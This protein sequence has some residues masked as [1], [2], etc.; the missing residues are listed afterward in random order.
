MEHL[1]S[2]SP[3]IKV[4][5]KWLSQEWGREQGYTLGDTEA[6]CREVGVSLLVDCDLETEE[7]YTPW[8]SSLYVVPTYRGCGVGSQLIEATVAAALARGHDLLYLYAKIGPL[9]DYYN[10]LGWCISKD[11]IIITESYRITGESQDRYFHHAVRHI[12]YKTLGS[13]MY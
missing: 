3:E 5:A 10:S 11:L 12:I 1:K 2:D 6:W 9:T 13:L 8:L 4:V 7:G